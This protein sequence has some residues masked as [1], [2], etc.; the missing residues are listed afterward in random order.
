MRNRRRMLTCLMIAALAVVASDMSPAQMQRTRR[1]TGASG[2]IEITPFYGYMGE[3]R[4]N[5]YQGEIIYPARSIFGGIVNYTVQPGLQG[6]L[7][8]AYM[9][10]ELQLREDFV[11]VP[12]KLFDMG[13]HY[14]LLGAVY[15]PRVGS[16]VM[17]YG[18]FSGGFTIYDPSDA[19]YRSEWRFTL[20]LAGGVK[21]FL[22]DRIGIR[23][24]GRVLTPMQFTGGGFFIGSGGASVGVSAGIITF[25]GD[26]LGG[27]TIRL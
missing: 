6:E 2:G 3:G 19:R 4:F 16:P 5:A 20:A 7:T 17:P 24:Q 11:G 26:V 13:V 14:I 22:S 10:T 12:Q 9:G 1:S 23:V 15:S 25:Q 21:V 8:Y 18:S 27:L